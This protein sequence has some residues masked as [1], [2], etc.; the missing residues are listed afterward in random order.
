MR[1]SLQNTI[2]LLSLFLIVPS[3]KKSGTVNTPAAG[4]NVYISGADNK[5]AVYWKN[6]TEVHLTN[7]NANAYASSIFV[8]AGNDVYVSGGETTAGIYSAGYW[9]NGQINYLTDSGAY[10]AA[11]YISVSGGDVY[12]AG[13]VEANN[14]SYDPHAVYWKDGQQYGYV[15]AN[16]AALC[17]FVSGTDVYIGGYLVNNINNGNNIIS[18][19]MYEKNNSFV[20]ISTGNVGSAY[21]GGVVQSL[22]VLGSNVYAAGYSYDTQGVFNYATIWSN[23]VPAI[24]SEQ[25]GSY[26]QGVFV[27]QNAVYVCGAEEVVAGGLNVAVATVWKN[28]VA[29]H[30]STQASSANSIYIS[31]G[32]VYVAGTT[33]NAQSATTAV[34]WK[35]GVITNLGPTGSAAST[36][37][38]K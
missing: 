22:Y 25:Q 19:A 3:C 29:T 15:S 34:Y 16:S 37:F 14:S 28:G 18:D 23:G 21:A 6:G 24:L 10:V 26:A 4:V 2:F 12:I 31:N 8:T 13:V 5:D 27:Y 7:G 36:I 38:V 1:I 30:L 17:G 9:K 20:D 32:D 33:T 11:N 35:N